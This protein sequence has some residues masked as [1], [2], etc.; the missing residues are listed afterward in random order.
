MKHLKKTC[1]LI[2]LL[3]VSF[4]VVIAQKTQP[5]PYQKKQLEL[6]KK[7][8]QILAG[9]EMSMSDEV[10]YEQLTAGKEANDFVLGLAI[11]N[12]AMYNSKSQ[13][14]KIF[15]Q[16]NNEFKQAEKLKNATD[17]RLE[18]EAKDLKEQ[19]AIEKTDFGSIRKNIKYAFEKWN[20]KGEFEKENDYS[21]RLQK[22]SHIAFDGICLEKIKDKIN[23]FSTYNWEKKLSTYDSENEFF[24]VFFKING[25]EWQSSIN[26]PISQAEKF[27]ID[28]P[29]FDFIM[30]VYDWSFVENSLFPS[31]VTLKKYDKTKYKFPVIL[32]NQSEISYSF[33]NLGIDNMYLK[34]YVFRYSNAKNIAEQQER[35]K[36]RLDSL[37]LVT[38]NQKLDSIF[39]DYN[40]QLLQN[41]YNVGKKV[42]SDYKKVAGKNDREYYFKNSLSSIKYNY[43][44]LNKAFTSEYDNEYRKNGKLFAN[45]DE[46]DTFYKKGIEDYQSEIEKRTTMNYLLVNSQFIES[47]DF[48]KEKKEPISPPNF[49]GYSTPTVDNTE[50]NKTRKSILSTISES[51]NKPYYSQVL[52]FVIVTNKEMNKEWNK[53]GQYFVSKSEFY[54][55][56]ISVDYKKILKENKKK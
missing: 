39:N 31:V 13:C 17:F 2:L 23:N 35:E 15:T 37:E 28:W 21:V 52:D 54:N 7:W 42:M 24:T 41:P 22:Q 4:N 49:Y 6:S 46:F 30:D 10:F 25:I 11:L 19:E 44:Q 34:G 36:Q 53:N 55:A 12:Y 26:I 1:L 50:I 40:R 29:D 27:K 33:D 20:Q 51:K 48:Q 18:K 45:K 56:Y 47:M 43:E 14:E 9:Y 3:F 8:F 16:M 38:Y 5:T 32:N